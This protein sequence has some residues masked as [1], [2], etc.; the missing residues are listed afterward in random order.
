MS[1]QLQIESLAYGGAGVGRR[2]GRAVF[3]EGAAPGDLLDVEPQPGRK[4]PLRA[5]LL[6]VVQPG[7]GRVE[8]ICP[9]YGDCGGCQW[10]HVDPAAQ[11]EAKRRSLEDALLR[12]GKISREDLPQIQA[13][14][15]PSQ[16]RYRRR[17]RLAVA[18]DGRLGFMARGSNRVVRIKSCDLL[19]PDLERLALALSEALATRPIAGLAA[20]E[21]C[22]ADGKDAVELEL[23]EGSNVAEARARAADLLEALPQLA[24]IVVSSK[25]ERITVGDPVLRDGPLLLRPDVFAQA[26]REGNRA[27]VALAVEALAARPTDPALEL[28]CGSGNFSFA[29]APQVA[30]LLAIEDEGA[31]LA[32]A[33]RALPAELVSRVSF[34]ELPVVEALREEAAR[35]ARFQVA[36]LDP[37]RAGAKEVVAMLAALVERRIVYVSCD[38][39]TLARDV[40]EFFRLGWKPLRA[41]V[42]DL[43][44]QTYHL[45]AV[46]VLERR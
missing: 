46:I 3:V 28:Y 33:K 11:L 1:Y 23:G 12:V 38:P 30:S 7:P 10:Q 24:G 29:I 45:E 18:S 19:E 42:L 8:P 26:S 27:L 13:V 39:A 15:A 9:H 20:V 43:F 25:H 2:E 40:A 35:G 16:W 44:P 31:A 37:P 5:R 14:A 4:S 17:A 6:S 22:I 32:L 34:R 21:L 36:L 41:T